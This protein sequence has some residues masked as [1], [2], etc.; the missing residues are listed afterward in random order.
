MV[1]ESIFEPRVVRLQ[2]TAR[3]NLLVALKAVNDA[4]LALAMLEQDWGEPVVRQGEKA[5]K[6]RGLIEQL[7]EQLP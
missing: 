2:L 1:S 7:T 3:V 4:C 5:R 6:I